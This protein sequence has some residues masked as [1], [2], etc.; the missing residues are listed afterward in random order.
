MSIAAQRDYSPCT[1]PQTH[2]V[3]YF[4]YAIG[5]D[6][7]SSYYGTQD[8]FF[9]LKAQSWGHIFWVVVGLELLVSVFQL[10]LTSPPACG[11]V[12]WAVICAVWGGSPGGWRALTWS[13]D[14]WVYKGKRKVRRCKCCSGKSNDMQVLGGKCISVKNMSWR[15][16]K[17]ECSKANTTG[18]H[19]LT[20]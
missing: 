4:A 11:C 20:C 8:Q 14:Q 1:T 2:P 15:R 18:Q 10:L 3:Q 19:F 5:Q 17:W 9:H 16:K 6:V 13:S 12:R 7:L